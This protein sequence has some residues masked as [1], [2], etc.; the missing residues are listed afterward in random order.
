MYNQVFNYQEL[1]MRN[2]TISK[3]PLRHFESALLKIPLI[4]LQLNIIYNQGK[5]VNHYCHVG[6]KDIGQLIDKLK[7]YSSHEV[8]L[9]AKVN[10]PSLGTRNDSDK[11]TTPIAQLVP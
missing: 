8:E 4:E 1:A 3:L 11:D 9:D 10:I 5:T 6:V 2:I 7:G